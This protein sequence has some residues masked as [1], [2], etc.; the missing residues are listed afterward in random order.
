MVVENK[1][2]TLKPGDGSMQ[3]EDVKLQSVGNEY[4]GIIKHVTSDLFYM[5]SALKKDKFENDESTFVIGIMHESLF[6]RLRDLFKMK[7][8]DMRR[9]C[10]SMGIVAQAK[11]GN[12]MSKTIKPLIK[13]E[14]L[15][16]DAYMTK[17]FQK[18]LD[19]LIP[20]KLVS[21][22][23]LEDAVRRHGNNKWG[24]AIWKKLNKVWCMPALVFESSEIIIPEALEEQC[25]QMT[26]KPLTAEM[27]KLSTKRRRGKKLVD[28]D[29][30]DALN[31]R[32][33]VTISNRFLIIAR[34]IMRLYL[35]DKL[36]S[37]AFRGFFITGLYILAKWVISGKMDKTEY[38]FAKLISALDIA[39]S[40]Y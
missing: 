20:Q 22:E 32:V 30:V 21:R 31:L 3:D 15:E 35:P 7:P 40:E 4:R 38:D 14:R 5:F 28:D 10:V 6:E 13:M 2:K 36:K 33:S 27:Y 25:R 16:R 17:R 8:S 12:I 26:A 18:S 19:R 39:T 9:A 11:H 23:A 29:D 1:L 24:D 34:E 37:Q